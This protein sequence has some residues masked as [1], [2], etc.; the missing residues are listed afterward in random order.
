MSDDQTQPDL[1]H[2]GQPTVFFS[3]SRADQEAALPII[4]AIQDAGYDLWWDGMLEAGSKYLE[5]TES[6]LNNAKAII[7]LWSATSVTSNWVRDEAMVGRDKE[8]MIPLSLDGT[9]PPLGFRQYQVTHFQNWNQRADGPEMDA[10]LRR[11][12]K[13]HNRPMPARHK[14]PRSAPPLNRRTLLLAGAATLVAGSA[15]TGLTFLRRKP[16]PTIASNGLVVLPFAN[17]SGDPALDY[18]SS[19]I[20]AELRSA[21]MRNSALRVVAQRSSEAL[22]AKGMDAISIAKE[23]G[24]GFILDGNLRRSGDAL[25]MSAELVEGREGFSI[26]SNDFAAPEKNL[27]TV[28]DELVSAIAQTMSGERGDTASGGAPS[29]PEA[30]DAY[31]RGIGVWK[32]A[33]TPEEARDALVFLDR[34]VS[35]DPRFSACH[36]VRGLILSWLS[37]SS[38]DKT[39]SQ[40]LLQSALA[41]A[42]SAI[43]YGPDLAAAHSTKGWVEFFSAL[44]IRAAAEPFEKSR[45]LGQGDAAI[46]ARYA[47]YASLV[48]KPE[49]AE[50]AI[51]KALALD[52]LNPYMHNSAAIVHYYARNYED[53]LASSRAALDLEPDMGVARFWVGM[54]QISLGKPTEAISVCE[55]EPNPDARY[56]CEAIAHARNGSQEG[57]TSALTGLREAFGDN[58]AYQR[59]QI[60]AQTGD[61]DA[62]MAELQRAAQSKDAGV[63][64]AFVDPMLDPLRPREDFST[65]LRR[66]GFDTV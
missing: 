37:S 36:S 25:R 22:A 29:S 26:W 15:V 42:Q 38:A 58:I 20:S 35:L 56:T 59:A 47:T 63:I 16:A 19:G 10:L 45:I 66:L 33:A 9:E 32:A 48:R 7:V 44:N 23:L 8:R 55:D 51:G 13:V 61:L 40:A 57:V 64:A 28:Q 60:F 17:L 31:L 21:L 34:A 46:L 18:I 6:V 49:A 65:L 30:Y 4:R 12:A 14:L 27:I 41:A 5:K 53:A 24:V 2:D 3:Y 52:P 39:E 1:A 43:T 62:A 54:S 11:L 50:S